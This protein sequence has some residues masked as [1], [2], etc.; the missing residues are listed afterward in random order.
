LRDPERTCATGSQDREAG[1]DPFEP[2][3]AKAG[4]ARAAADGSRLGMGIAASAAR[5]ENALAWM[6]RTLPP[7]DVAIPTNRIASKEL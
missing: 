4:T 5:A 7:S 3:G 6:R 1:D 2:D